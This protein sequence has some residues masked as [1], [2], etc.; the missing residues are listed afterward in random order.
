MAARPDYMTVVVPKDRRAVINFST[1]IQW[2][3]KISLSEVKTTFERLVVTRS[4][5]HISIDTYS[6]ISTTG[7]ESFVFFP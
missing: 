2:L 5:I 7:S 4:I 1:T 6:S 3:V